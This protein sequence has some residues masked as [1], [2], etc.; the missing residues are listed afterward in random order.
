MAWPDYTYNIFEN[1]EDA[2]LE[3]GLT[4]TDTSGAVTI[5][6]SAQYYIDTHSMALN[7]SGLTVRANISYGN[8]GNTASFGFWYRSG[9]YGGWAGGP[10][11]FNLKSNAYGN[12]IQMI[13]ERSA[14]DNTRRIRCNN[15]SIEVSDYTF[16]CYN[17]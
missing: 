9:S 14:G 3:S 1:F 16:I 7:L 10:M 2:T 11:I 5:P 4:L 12:L 13:D 6:S 17:N 8:C 15:Q